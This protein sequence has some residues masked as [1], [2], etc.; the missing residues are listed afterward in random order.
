MKS[1]IAATLSANQEK[2][3]ATLDSFTGLV[4]I[5]YAGLSYVSA[6]LKPAA[7][8]RWH[9]QKEPQ[10][11]KIGYSHFRKRHTNGCPC[12]LPLRLIAHTFSSSL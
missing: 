10:T 9:L 7:D 12:S 6:G 4:P 11:Y 3:C 5:F 1:V 2:R 8:P